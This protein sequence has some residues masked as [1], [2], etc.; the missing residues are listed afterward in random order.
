[1]ACGHSGGNFTSSLGNEFWVIAQYD[2]LNYKNDLGITNLAG[3]DKLA[4]FFN[5]EFPV[6]NGSG[7]GDLM[8][9]VSK[10]NGVALFT[11]VTRAYTGWTV[12][13]DQFENR[14]PGVAVNNGTTNVATATNVKWVDVHTMTFNIDL[15]GVPVGTYNIVVSNGC[16]TH[17]KG[18][19]I[20]MLKVLK[21]I[22]TVGTPNIDV[23]T[24]NGTPKDIA[25]DP[26][27]GQAAISYST[28]WV[29]WTNNYTTSS[30]HIDSWYDTIT[31][32]YAK[33]AWWMR[34]PGSS[35]IA[36]TK[37]HG[38]PAITRPGRGPT[39]PATSGPAP[40]G[41]PVLETG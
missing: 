30:P 23:V 24:G 16:G 8:P 5:I 35:G 13:G 37:A 1:M 36:S 22:H 12:T 19:G 29:K 21:Y 4:A 14:V 18:V 27:T 33:M 15:T 25:V 41:N 7:C 34:I 40:R 39:G 11:A 3:D 28:Y 6:N 9:V 32:Q 10:L 2:S 38:I 17:K 20:G 31:G 26:S